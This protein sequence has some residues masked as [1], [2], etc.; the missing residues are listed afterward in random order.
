MTDERLSAAS[1]P[2][3]LAE[4]D[5]VETAITRSRTFHRRIDEAG[6]THLQV[7]PELLALAEREEQIV[8]ELR[9][10]TATLAA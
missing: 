5:S 4:L 6:R 9:R 3:L 1:R 2:E 8:S 7:S 10:R